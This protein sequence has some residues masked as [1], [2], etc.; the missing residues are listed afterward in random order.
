[1]LTSLVFKAPVR[2]TDWKIKAIKLALLLERRGFL[3]RADFRYFSVAPT[4]WM[5]GA[6]DDV[7]LLPGKRRGEW[8]A[9]PNFPDFENQ[10][11]TVYEEIKAD[12][13]AWDPERNQLAQKACG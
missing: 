11:P 9:G 4:R 5:Q 3:T 7:W 2:L 10:H 12:F 8:V 6:V 13:D 1:M